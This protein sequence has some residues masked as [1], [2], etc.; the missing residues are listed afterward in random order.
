MLEH[1]VLKGKAKWNVRCE[2]PDHQSL[3]LA[4]NSDEI[5]Y[6]KPDGVLSFDRLSSVYLSI[7]SMK[8]T[9][10]VICSLPASAFL[11]NRTWRSMPSPLNATVL[12]GCMKL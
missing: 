3:I 12:L 7:F 2:H 9:N 6:P 11:S 4:E 1:N 10:R 5:L 8:K